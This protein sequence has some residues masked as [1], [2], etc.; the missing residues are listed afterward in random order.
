MMACPYS[1]SVQVT[2]LGEAIK[3]RYIDQFKREPN[4][5][6]LQGYD[7]MF[8]LLTAIKAAN[9]TDSKAIIAELDKT[10]LMGTRGEITFAKAKGVW[11]NQWKEVPAF[12][13]QY[14]KVDQSPADAAI[15]FPPDF[16]NA[17]IAKPAN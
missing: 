4:Y 5:L 17:K 15:L 13:F 9:S 8:T 2:D 14:T 1:S 12:I 11:H 6:P 16:A 7:A 10:K 3:Q